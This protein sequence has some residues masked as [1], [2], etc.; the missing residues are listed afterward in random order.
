MATHIPRE[1]VMKKL[2]RQVLLVEFN[3]TCLKYITIYL[4]LAGN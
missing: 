3:K 1:N 2:N 4:M